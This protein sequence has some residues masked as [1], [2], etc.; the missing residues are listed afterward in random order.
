MAQEC[1]H[2]VRTLL[3]VH[4]LPVFALLR[5]LCMCLHACMRVC[6]H[7][8]AHTDVTHADTR[9]RTQTSRLT[10]GCAHRRHEGAHTDVTRRHEGAHTDVT[11]ASCM[12][13]TDAGRRTQLERTRGLG[14]RM[15]WGCKVAREEGPEGGGDGGRHNADENLERQGGCRE[16]DGK[17]HCA[18]ATCFARVL[19]VH[20]RPRHALAALAHCEAWAGPDAAPSRAPPAAR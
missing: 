7:E 10:R 12:Q 20:P 17:T 13:L 19:H 11:H 18:T 5:V 8:R 16:E 15:S 4:P 1:S 6:R 3:V 14:C 9:V 2:C